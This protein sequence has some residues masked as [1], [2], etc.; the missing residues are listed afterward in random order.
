MEL[1]TEMGS[2][3]FMTGMRERKD[4]RPDSPEGSSSLEKRRVMHA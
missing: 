1:Q 4:S 3:T 2:A